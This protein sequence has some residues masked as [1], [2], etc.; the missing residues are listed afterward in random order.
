MASP[1]LLFRSSK[2]LFYIFRSNSQFL[3]KNTLARKFQVPAIVQKPATNSLTVISRSYAKGKDRKKESKHKAV[4]I[5][6]AILSQAINV[7][8]LKLQMDRVVEKMKDDFVKHFTLR[9]SLGVLDTL[10]VEFDGT[11]YT[12]QDLAQ[13]GKKNPTMYVID[14]SSFP[15]VIPDVLK[16]IKASGL[17][18]NPQ[19][20]GT[21]LFIPVPKI[22]KDHRETLSKNAKAAFIKTRD[23]LRDVQNKFIRALKNK[24]GLSEDVVFSVKEQITFL[25]DQRIAEAEG[26]LKT[27]QEELKG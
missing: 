1:M 20:D 15:Q 14:L 13:I 21:T 2:R 6:E 18:L 26:I 19:Q 24:D 12:L 8:D 22:T 10:P 16:S 9:T 17:G 4:I 23:S 27:K 25:A 3:S 11:D 7:E 5:N